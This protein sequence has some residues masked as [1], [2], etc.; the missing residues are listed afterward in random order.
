MMWDNEECDRGGI[1]SRGRHVLKHVENVYGLRGAVI[2]E[3]GEI[4][5]DRRSRYH[6]GV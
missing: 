4:R 1:W 5:G 3:F 2:F 6:V